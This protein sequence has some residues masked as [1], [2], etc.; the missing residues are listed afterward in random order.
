[1]CSVCVYLKCLRLCGLWFSRVI[2]LVVLRV[3]LLLR[4]ISVLCLLVL[5]CLV[6]LWILVRLGLFD[7]LWNRLWLML[8]CFR[9][10]CI[11][12]RGFRVSMLGLVISRGWCV[13]VSV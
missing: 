2:F 1:M 9:Y 6:L 5:K 4:V 7:S 13:F 12:C 8:V 10:L 3:L 11:R